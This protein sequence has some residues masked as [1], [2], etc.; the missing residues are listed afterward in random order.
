MALSQSGD[1]NA[2]YQIFRNS[3]NPVFAIDGERR[4]CFWNEACEELM[5]SSFQ[6]V[7]GRTCYSVMAGVDVRRNP[8]CG[9]D[10]EVSHRLLQGLPVKD[11]DMVIQT[12]EGDNILVNV[13]AYSVPPELRSRESATAFLSL[14]RVDCYRL[15]E[16]LESDEH[17][18]WGVCRPEKHNLTPRELEVLEL[19]ANGFGTTQIAEELSISTHTAKNHFKNIFSKLKVHSRTEAVSL[20]LRMN[21]F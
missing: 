16:R 11:Y 20:A 7:R 18:K 8:F 10:C 21:F 5:G 14:R 12:A 1:A 9:P 4:I 15:L 3:F 17:P 2:F 13:G 19:A 6:E